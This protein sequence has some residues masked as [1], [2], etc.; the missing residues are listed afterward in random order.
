MV[1][2]N[3]NHPEKVESNE[4][5]KEEELFD[6]QFQLSPIRFHIAC[7]QAHKAGVTFDQWI[8]NMVEEALDQIY[9]EGPAKF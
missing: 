3:S 6:V 4:P 2:D 1:E 9:Q 8:A 5:V 7:I